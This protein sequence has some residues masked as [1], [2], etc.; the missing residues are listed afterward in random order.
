MIRHTLA[1][2]ALSLAAIPLVA[3]GASAATCGSIIETLLT[4]DNNTNSPANEGCELGS[5]KEF[6]LAQINDDALFGKSD[7]KPGADLGLSLVLTNTTASSGSWEV[8]LNLVSDLASVEH[9]LLAFDTTDPGSGS[10]GVDPATYVA[11]RIDP[12][13]TLSGT[14]TE[15]FF[16]LD[17]TKE[18][19]ISNAEVYVTAAAPIPVPA[20]LPLV[21][22]GVGALALMRRRRKAG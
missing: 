16:D 15:L 3:S 14:Y 12:S 7:W 20:A 6:T 22:T 21:A 13:G 9:M 1:A 19:A 8:T 10:Q 17:G 18:A 2:A 11:Y 4:Q 5:T